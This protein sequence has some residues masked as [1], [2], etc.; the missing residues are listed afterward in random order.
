[1]PTFVVEDGSAKSDANSY[2]SIADADSYFDNGTAPSTWTD[3][4]EADKQK[5]LRIATSYVSERYS[6][7]WRGVIQSDTQSL[8][9]PR[10]GV[11]DAATGLVY[12]NDE[13]PKKLLNATAEVALRYLSGTSLR[14]DVKP[15]EGNVTNSSI[16]VGAISISEDFV[17]SATTATQF[18][19]VHDKL[20]DLLTDMG[21]GMLHRV[22]R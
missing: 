17:G 12:D 15:G 6:I 14:P 22:T 5:A 7:R 4:T 19:E 8:D 3:A 9:W 11:V 16:T 10:N 13:M 21:A 18:P 2:V 1:M 20:R